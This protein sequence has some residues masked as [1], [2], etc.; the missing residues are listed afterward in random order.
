MS[1][2]D[3]VMFENVLE[4][5]KVYR[6]R[7]EVRKEFNLTREESVNCFRWFMKF[8]DDFDIK[9]KCGITGK[10]TWIKTKV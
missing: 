7:N 8:K 1:W 9:Y 10:A 3:K 2:K 5:C 6:D 4:F